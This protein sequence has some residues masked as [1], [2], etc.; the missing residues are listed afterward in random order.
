[1]AIDRRSC[2]YKSLQLLEEMEAKF[3]KPLTDDELEALKIRGQM[4]QA[5][6]TLATAQGVGQG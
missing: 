3:G 4:A 1:M 2:Y 6:A 5:Y